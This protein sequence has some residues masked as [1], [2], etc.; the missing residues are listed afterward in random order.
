MLT[1][2]RQHRRN[3]LD[4]ATYIALANALREADADG[5]VRAIIITGAGG[6][7]TS[8]NDLDDFRRVPQPSPRGG[9][10]LFGALVDARKPVIAAIEGHA[11]GIGV[12]M[13]LHCD[14][15][16]ASDEAKFRLPFT[17]LGLSPEGASSYLLPLLAGEKKA[18]ELLLLSE[19]FTAAEA[20]AAGL[21]NGVVDAGRA[22]AEATQRASAIAELPVASIEATKA[23]VRTHR[24][25]I[26]R[27][28][29]A[30]EYRVFTARL[31]DNAVHAATS[32]GAQRA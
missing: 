7:F 18:L 23:L 31:T 26:V 5:Q 13:L 12:T 16:Y 20:V 2:D 21:V 14:L 22:L 11:V 25:P 10:L 9:S 3:A 29:L 15:A 19:R 28:V 4:Y 32:S 1:I 24:D 30:T 17:A 27:E 6:T 8:G